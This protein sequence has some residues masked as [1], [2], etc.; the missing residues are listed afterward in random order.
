MNDNIEIERIICK[1]AMIDVAVIAI[2]FVV[3][4]VFVGGML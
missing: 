2:L 3:M 1:E 4:C